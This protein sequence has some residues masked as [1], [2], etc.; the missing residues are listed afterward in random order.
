MTTAIMR[1]LYLALLETLPCPVSRAWPQD[2]PSLPGCV[3]R[4]QEWRGDGEGAAVCTIRLQLRAATPAQGDD[5]GQMALLAM[6]GL[7]FSLVKAWDAQEGQTGFFLRE[8]QFEAPGWQAADGSLGLHALPPAFR[9]QAGTGWLILPRAPR[10]TL[11]AGSRSPLNR[12][13]LSQDRL[14]LPAFLASRLQPGVLQVSAGFVP[15]DPAI[16]ALE[17]AFVRGSDLAFGIRYQGPGFYDSAG[18]VTAFHASPL[19]LRF[20]LALRQPFTPEPQP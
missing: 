11:E 6:A 20:S 14:P 3:F 19:G 12:A 4:L 17:E 5:L 1:R 16:Q 13:G 9:V 18:L 7:Q 15:G 10:F 2:K 8:M